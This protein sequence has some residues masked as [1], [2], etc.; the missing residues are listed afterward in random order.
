MGCGS[1][2][3]IIALA[4]H[5]QGFEFV[6]IDQKLKIKGGELS[7]CLLYWNFETEK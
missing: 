3:M 7:S 2:D 6:G 1:G 4:L 5:F